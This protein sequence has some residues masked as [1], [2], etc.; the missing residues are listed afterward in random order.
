MLANAFINKTDAPTTDELAAALGPAKALWDKLLAELPEDCNTHEWNSYSRKAGWSLRVKREK[1]VIV[2]LV[3]S[4]GSF[5]AAFVLGDRAVE[6]AKHSGIPQKVIEIIDG[7]KRYAEGTG[8][9]IEVA[10]ARDLPAIKKLVA[11]KLQN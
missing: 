2:Y 5:T 4:H 9:R 1:R 3:P 6:A 7:S 8:V 10:G 11:V